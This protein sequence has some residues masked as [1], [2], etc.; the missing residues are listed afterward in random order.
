MSSFHFFMTVILLISVTS[1][2]FSQIPHT[3]SYQGM[4][5]VSGDEVV[6]DGIYQM[7]FNLYGGTE[8]STS[9]WSETYGVTVV[10]GVFNVISGL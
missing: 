4:L 10:K 1:M 9:L 5:A 3:L 8:P 7:H 2:V 6:E